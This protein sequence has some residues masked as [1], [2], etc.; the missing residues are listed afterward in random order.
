MAAWTSFAKTP[1]KVVILPT[2]GGSGVEERKF[3]LKT[4]EEGGGGKTSWNNSKF[5]QVFSKDGLPYWFSNFCTWN[6]E[7]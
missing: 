3:Q 7:I 1:F 5:D 2:L 4:R 6:L